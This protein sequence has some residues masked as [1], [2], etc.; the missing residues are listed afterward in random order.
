MTQWLSGY[1]ITHGHIRTQR[2]ICKSW[3][4]KQVSLLCVYVARRPGPGRSHCYVC[5]APPAHV[6]KL[7][8]TWEPHR[9][10]H[11]YH[12]HGP[13]PQTGTLAANDVPV[14]TRTSVDLGESLSPHYSTNQLDSIYDALNGGASSAS[15]NILPAKCLVPGSFLPKA[16]RT[17]W[18]HNKGLQAKGHLLLNFIIPKSSVFY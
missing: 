9:P 12:G 18:I 13:Y 15:L 2:G 11:L 8:A 5:L 4:L 14:T 6:H 10:C 16:I 3:V 7:T 17:T 1:K